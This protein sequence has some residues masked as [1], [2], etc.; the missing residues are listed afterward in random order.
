MQRP[1]VPIHHEAKKGYFVAF[2]NAFFVWHEDQMNELVRRMKE[3]GLSDGEIERMRYYNSKVFTDCVQREVPPPSILYWR[4]RA[5]FALYGGM[6]DSKTGKPL[7]NA[8]AWVKARG[9]LNEILEGYYSDPPGMCMYTKRLRRNGS[10]RTNKYGMDM[11]ECCRGTNR[12]EAYHKNLVIAF[13]N[14]NTGIEMS[15]C[16]LS[17]RRH[18]HNHRCSERRRF[19]FPIL[20]H[21]DTW[22]IDALQVIILNNRGRVL[23]PNWSN[24]SEYKDTDESF[25][26]VAIHSLELD[27]ALKK[28]WDNRINQQAVKLTSDQRYLCRRMGIPLPFLPFTTEEESKVF[29]EC[30]LSMEFPMGNAEEAAIEWCK[31]VDGVNVFPK[32]PVHIRVHREAFMRNQRVKNCIE[33][34]RTGQAKL[35]E[36]NSAV[37]PLASNL[38]PAAI[39]ASM[40]AIQPNAMHNDEYIVTAGTGVGNLPSPSIKRKRGERGQDKN[41]RRARRCGRC[42][43]NNGQHAEMCAGRGGRGGV[44]NC[45]Y[46][47]VDGNPK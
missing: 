43:E 18:R 30:A 36:L 25:D 15:D 1:Y 9:I 14:W 34:A 2:Q 33:L 21:Y 35:D 26:T 44:D 23:Y 19:G 10:V 7:F 8:K 45:Q 28:E 42:V 38:T 22:L 5:V 16:L 29:A 40:P 3:S 41:R 47:R 6:K 20:G 39:P 32:L 37:K 31:Y 24:A 46:F 12:T 4:V 13:R 11:I 27:V 17:E